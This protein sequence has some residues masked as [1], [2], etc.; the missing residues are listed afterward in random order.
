MTTVSLLGLRLG[1]NV[2]MIVAETATDLQHLILWSPIMDGERY[3]QDLLR[4]NLMTQ[5]ATLKVIHQE[6]PALVADD[7]PAV[8]WFIGTVRRTNRRG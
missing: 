5:M 8:V 3:L 6:R 1:A 7:D 4:I 2:A